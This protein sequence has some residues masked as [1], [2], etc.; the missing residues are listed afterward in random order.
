[1]VIFRIQRKMLFSR[2]RKLERGFLM[3][4]RSNGLCQFGFVAAIAIMITGAPSSLSAQAPQSQSPISTTT[5][6]AASAAG[7]DATTATATGCAYSALSRCS[8]G[9]GAHRL[10]LSARSGDG[11]ALVRKKF[12]RQRPRT[13][14]RYAEATLGCKHQRIDGGPLGSRDDERKAG[15]D[16]PARRGISGAAR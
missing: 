12:G 1:M 16:Q 13:R 14:G 9:P 6:A 11:C 4:A 8:T 3:S 15:L 2:C 5:T 7:S 10:D